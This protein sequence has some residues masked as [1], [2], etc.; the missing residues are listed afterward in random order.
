MT[1][2]DVQQAEMAARNTLLAQTVSAKKAGNWH[3]MLVTAEQG[4]Q[5]YPDWSA[6][7][8][9]QTGQ[10]F[11]LMAEQARKCLAAA[12]Q[13]E[14]ST[15]E[16]IAEAVSAPPF[17]A[18]VAAPRPPVM[19]PAAQAI[20]DALGQ[21]SAVPVSVRPVSARPVSVA[22]VSAPPKVE[23][24]CQPGGPLDGGISLGTITIWHNA[25]QG[26]RATC[27][28]GDGTWDVMGKTGQHWNYTRA[29]RRGT[30]ALPGYYR[31]GNTKGFVPDMGRIDWATYALRA[32]GF[33]VVHQIDETGCAARVASQ[34]RRSAVHEALWAAKRQTR[35][36]PAMGS[37][38]PVSGAPVSAQPVSVAPVS[39][40]PVYVA[41]VSAAP[42]S[43]APV[44]VQPVSAAPVSAAPF[45]A[46]LPAAFFAAMS[47]QELISAVAQQVPGAMEYA[48][49]AFS[50][51]APAPVV[52]VAPVSAPP[53]VEI[54]VDVLESDST[55][56]L[57]VEVTGDRFKTIGSEFRS[58]MKV[59][60]Q[61]KHV[62]AKR[63]LGALK[64]DITVPAGVD[65]N[66][67]RRTVNEVCQVVDGVANSFV[68]DDA[69]V[70]KLEI[71][72]EALELAA[73]L[74]NALQG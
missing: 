61:G 65:R 35:V 52:A 5:Q 63:Q 53:A 19:N 10:P 7:S 4:M 41:P 37:D 47:M 11:A 60:E 18:P 55:L 54:P 6:T 74:A 26:T 33:A 50:G 1:N 43:A 29:M 13:R 44:S 24:G 15:A 14:L 12:V 46:A 22:P 39:V 40:Q 20:R 56:T 48:N 58:Y 45:Q 68:T 28:K 67:I 72:L 49:I 71:T 64:V 2:I 3:T 9:G 62:Y 70:A 8:N 17:I 25:E 69:R 51:Q 21:V 23:L 32:A 27:V 42:V 66:A 57:W 16:L 73:D 30:D 31:L 34:S 59:L 38:E 36:T